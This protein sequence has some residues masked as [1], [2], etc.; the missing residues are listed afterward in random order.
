M[1]AGPAGAFVLVAL[2]AI[3]APGAPA[4][5]ATPSVPP[6]T[7]GLSLVAQPLNG[8]VPLVVDFR[9][10]VTPTTLVATFNWTFGDGSTY[11]ETATSY[12]GIAHFY[13]VPGTYRAM[14][15]A[16]SADGDA[17][18][19][20]SVVARSS[21]LT[22]QILATP[23]SGP[24]PLTVHFVTTIQGGTGTY[25]AI[26]WRF[27]DG[28]NGSG[29]DLDYTYLRAGNYVAVLNVSDSTGESATSSVPIAVAPNASAPGGGRAASTPAYAAFALP[30]ALALAAGAVVALVYRAVLI[31]RNDTDVTGSNPT[32]NPV[33][34]SP[35][36][37]PTSARGAVGP[38]SPE[39]MVE[40]TTAQPGR[41]ESRRLSE[42]ILVHLYWYGRP[43]AEGVARADSSQAGM[44]RRLGVAQNSISKS[45]QRLID[46]GVVTMELRH[47]PGAAR[48]LRTYTLTPRGEAVARSIRADSERRRPG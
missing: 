39:A 5:P 14:V 1:P 10:T 22:V 47:V 7:I 36:P 27:G 34:P 24:A 9:A 17:N 12:S 4:R 37:T 35:A 46:S 41:E 3:A 43:T 15:Y 44:A 8:T 11:Q 31:R 18:A 25:T 20:L 28:G 45:L 32:A 26:V 19:S 40:V 2:I 38:A 23:L 42:R 16:R 29:S 30:I 6:A 48:R 13:G 33:S 21:P